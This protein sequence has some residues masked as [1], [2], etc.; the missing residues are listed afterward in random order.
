[1]W[2]GALLRLVKAWLVGRI[3][4]NELSRLAQ[5]I[6]WGQPHAHSLLLY[7]PT[8]KRLKVKDLSFLFNI[9]NRVRLGGPDPKTAF[10]YLREVTQSDFSKG[11][12]DFREKIN[13]CCGNKWLYSHFI[14]EVR[15]NQTI[16]EKNKRNFLTI[17][18]Y[19]HCIWTFLTDNLCMPALRLDTL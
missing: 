2:A 19:L 11:C 4:N 14:D 9:L 18:I 17:L 1:M 13:F 12:F 16:E 3:K 10:D 7:N 15:P 5:S 6:C 8:L